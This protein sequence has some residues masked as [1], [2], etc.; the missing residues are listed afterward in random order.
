M[1]INLGGK[2]FDSLVS[3]GMID[4][5]VYP[6]AKSGLQAMRRSRKIM[7]LLAAA[8]FISLGVVAL[9]KGVEFAL[10]K[11]ASAVPEY[12]P[13]V[14]DV[15][16]GTLR[17][18]TIACVVLSVLLILSLLIWLI[19]ATRRWAYHERRCFANDW[20]ACSLRKRVLRATSVKRRLA[21]LSQSNSA[22]KR[23]SQSNRSKREALLALKNI[24]IESHTRRSLDVD[25]LHQEIIATIDI[26]LDELAANELDNLSKKLG[27]TLTRACRGRFKFG[28]PIADDNYARMSL[29]ASALDKAAERKEAKLRAKGKVIADEKSQYESAFDIELFNDTAK[30]IAAKRVEAERW[31]K[32]VSP[33]LDKLLATGDHRVTQAQQVVT[34]ASVTYDYDLPFSL[35]MSSID[36]LAD[37]LNRLFKTSSCSAE[38]YEGSLR[39][40]MPLPQKNRIGID[41]RELYTDAFGAK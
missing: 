34:A 26:P 40:I 8:V 3:D 35:N 36:R 10:V 7:K 20:F 15:Y 30:E 11:Y 39:I 28:D 29:N 23:V 18:C 5:G 13:K 19:I 12:W 16:N 31:A 9:Y 21:D 32:S 17:I 22:G 24:H 38:I 25:E 4:I 2:S 41:T 33:V 27:G 37:D 1:K 6:H 14:T